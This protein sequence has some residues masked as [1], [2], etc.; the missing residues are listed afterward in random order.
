[1]VFKEKNQDYWQ[2]PESSYVMKLNILKIQRGLLVNF[3]YDNQ[4]NVFFIH[5]NG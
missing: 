4:F 1:M 2:L 5:K 3:L